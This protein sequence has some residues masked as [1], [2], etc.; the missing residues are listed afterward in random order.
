MTE[1]ALAHIGA[2]A[3]PVDPSE[4][5]CE[6]SMPNASNIQERR[7]LQNAFTRLLMTERLDWNA[8]QAEAWRLLRQKKA[9]QLPRRQSEHSTAPLWCAHRIGSVLDGT[10][11]GCVTRG[12]SASP[13]IVVV[14][15]SQAGRFMASGR[16]GA[17]RAWT[18]HQL[19]EEE[20]PYLSMTVA[21][22]DRVS[23]PVEDSG[24]DLWSI[25]T[26]GEGRHELS[27]PVGP[28]GRVLGLYLIGN[29]VWFASM[30]TERGQISKV[31]LENITS[32]A[33]PELLDLDLIGLR[34]ILTVVND[35]GRLV[36]L[37]ETS[38]GVEAIQIWGSIQP[39]PQAADG[40]IP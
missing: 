19:S 5:T 27:T 4:F 30:R 16:A 35:E 28:I 20:T 29:E 22:R 11:E 26:F 3:T 13:L 15:H 34:R 40:R 7:A 37:G 31:A 8:V 38:R 24:T 2:A 18:C 1:A 14:G 10:I 6:S 36:A 21:L 23:V 25:V 17:K 12:T 32:P 33:P 9:D 39:V